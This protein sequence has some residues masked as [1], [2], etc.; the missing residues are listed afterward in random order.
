[1]W[2]GNFVTPKWWDDLWLNEAMAEF[3]S[4][5]AVQ[6]IYPDLDIVIF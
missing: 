3:L 4:Y 2:F 1:M 6:N 5:K